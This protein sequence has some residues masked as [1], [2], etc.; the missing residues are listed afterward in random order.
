MNRVWESGVECLMKV[1]QMFMTKSDLG[2]HLSSLRTW[3]NKLTNKFDRID[4]RLLTNCMRNS[5]KFLDPFFVKFFASIS[6]T[7][8]NCAKRV[9][10]MLADDHRKKTHG[11]CIDV[12]ESLS[13][14]RRKVSR[15]YCH[16][17]W[18]LSFPLHPWEQASI[19]RV[20]SY[21]IA[22]KTQEV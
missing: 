10:R 22:F 19:A 4:A 16:R 8:E 14:R 5:L 17:G 11:C 12:F 3:K 18:N 15:P 1:G 2:S 6:G 9:P 13:P 7:K 21:S 20:A